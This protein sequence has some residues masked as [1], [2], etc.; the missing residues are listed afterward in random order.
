MIQKLMVKAVV[1]RVLLMFAPT[2]RVVADTDDRTDTVA[3]GGEV[4]F[5]GSD[6]AEHTL[7]LLLMR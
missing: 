6:G 5:S 3:H 7:S 1:L 2:T 4:C